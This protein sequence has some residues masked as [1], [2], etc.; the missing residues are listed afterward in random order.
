MSE[1]KV[2]V[3]MP[4]YNSE[5]YLEKCIDSILEQDFDGFELLLVDDGST[6]KSAE[7]CDAYA[8]KDKRV[9]V[10]HISNSGICNARNYGLSQANG[11]Y[12][13]FSDHD[14][15]VKPG[16]LKKNFEY[17]KKYHADIVKFGRD[18]YYLREDEVFKKHFR[19]FDRRVVKGDEIK[20]EFLTLRLK[21]SMS[22]VWDS[23]IR[24]DFLKKNNIKFN[25]FYKK[26]GEDIDFSSKCYALAD[27]IAFNDEAYYVHYIRYGYSTSTKPDPNKLE[28]FCHLHENLNE[29]MQLLNI[30]KYDY[31]EAYILNYVKE[32][33][34]PS[35]VYFK[36]INS[37]T[38]DIIKFLKDTREPILDLKYSSGTMLKYGYKWSSFSIMYMKKCYHMMNLL[39][40]LKNK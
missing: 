26:G 9:R 12:I 19:R 6:D 33:V 18:T 25:T 15:C 32:F 4:V 22:C 31:A 16:F 11:E 35:L 10:F 2:S 38:S 30:S 39:L 37:K 5:K 21:D 8:Q 3:L 13:A 40:K 7:I 17:A 23:L 14:D 34:Y 1:L 36:S 28:K 29:C 24:N 27:V 20:K